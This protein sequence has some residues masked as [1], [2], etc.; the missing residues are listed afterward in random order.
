MEN[1]RQNNHAQL[2]INLDEAIKEVSKRLDYISEKVDETLIQT[3]KTNGRVTRLEK[4]SEE[5]KEKVQTLII[6]E[7]GNKG[8]NEVMAKVVNFLLPAAGAIILALFTFYL[9]RYK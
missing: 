8:K 1:V 6:N 5:T 9:G 3:T 2:L 4:D 7:A